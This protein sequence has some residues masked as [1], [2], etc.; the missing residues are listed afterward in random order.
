VKEEVQLYNLNRWKDAYDES[1]LIP[2]SRVDYVLV[3]LFVIQEGRSRP[4]GHYSVTTTNGRILRK[5]KSGLSTTLKCE[6][7]EAR[8]PF[9]NRVYHESILF[10]DNNLFC[11]RNHN[12]K[13]ATMTLRHP[14]YKCQVFYQER[15]SDCFS[16]SFNRSVRRSPF[17]FLPGNVYRRPRL[18][19]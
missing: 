4:L 18:H 1:E 13:L 7:R 8:E 14:S 10:L 17:T 3:V 5:A 19:Y 2:L 9:S 12:T 15:S 6:C 11:R 16:F